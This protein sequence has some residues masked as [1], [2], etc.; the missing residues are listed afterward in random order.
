MLIIFFTIWIY[1]SFRYPEDKAKAKSMFSPPRIYAE[2]EKING[3]S[4]EKMLGEVLQQ[5]QEI[6]KT[7][8]RSQH[9]YCS[10]KRA[11]HKKVARQNK[12]K[13]IKILYSGREDWVNTSKQHWCCKE[14]LVK[15]VRAGNSQPLY[16]N[17][18]RFISHHKRKH[19][20]MG[21][22]LW[23]TFKKF[24]MSIEPNT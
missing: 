15:H 21:D 19:W 5:I 8:G 12:D 17:Q 3:L 14:R 10:G 2:G 9:L 20:V 7:C 23:P 16:T 22:T 13:L 4:S 6:C 18:S 1:L 24:S 11:Q